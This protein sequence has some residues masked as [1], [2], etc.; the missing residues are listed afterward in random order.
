[1]G[2]LRIPGAGIW[3]DT[4]KVHQRGQPKEAANKEKYKGILDYWKD[5]Y[6]NEKYYPG[7]WFYA[8]QL[9]TDPTEATRG[10][11]NT[12]IRAQSGFRM[13][14]GGFYLDGTKDTRK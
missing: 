14:K 12:P 6:G 1:M 2:E 9:S 4:R 10:A 8:D 3:K 5:K 13:R 11:I 7:S